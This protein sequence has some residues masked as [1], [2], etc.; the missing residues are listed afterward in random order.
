MTLIEQESWIRIRLDL[1]DGWEKTND[2]NEAQKKLLEWNKGPFWW[3]DESKEY[4]ITLK[5]WKF[6]PY[7]L[8]N[9][10][11]ALPTVADK[12]ISAI[13]KTVND[14]NFVLK[15]NFKNKVNNRAEAQRRFKEWEREVFWLITDDN[16]TIA[17]LDYTKWDKPIIADYPRDKVSVRYQ[18]IAI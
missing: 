17:T 2:A 6:T 11:I 8:S 5:N 9:T 4:I 15:L 1:R 18:K 12:R 10:M 14:L 3:H 13:R 7:K 16:K